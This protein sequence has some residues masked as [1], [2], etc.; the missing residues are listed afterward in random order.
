MLKQVCRFHLLVSTAKYF[1]KLNS[2]KE[3]TKQKKSWYALKRVLCVCVSIY[4]SFPYGHQPSRTYI[5]LMKWMW[6]H[7]REGSSET[8]ACVQYLLSLYEFCS[9]YLE[10]TFPGRALGFSPPLFPTQSSQGALCSCSRPRGTPIQHSG[11]WETT[12]HSST[13][14]PL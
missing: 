4:V 8:S 6:H 14:R 12:L 13:D 1:Q 7:V 10:G 9:V 2:I 11:P 5:R 3:R